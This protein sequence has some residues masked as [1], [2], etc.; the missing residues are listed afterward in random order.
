MTSNFIMT[1]GRRMESGRSIQ[2]FIFEIL[3]FCY[4]LKSFSEPGPFLTLV[5]L[6]ARVRRRLRITSKYVEVTNQADR[7]M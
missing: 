5:G 3:L 4:N 6:G 7:W 1:E 2:P